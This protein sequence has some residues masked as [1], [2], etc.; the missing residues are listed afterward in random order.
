ML[1]GGGGQSSLPYYSLN[2][3]KEAGGHAVSMLR[4]GGGEQCEGRC[5]CLCRHSRIQRQEDTHSACFLQRHALSM[6]LTESLT[7][8]RTQ[9]LTETRTRVL[10]PLTETRTQHASYRD[11][12]RDTH[13]ACLL[14]RHALSMPLTEAAGHALSMLKAETRVR[15]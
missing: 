15:I 2:A 6:P 10:L 3:L 8:T 14:Q 7:E 12:Y 9:P 5:G 13:S 1:R 11:S 4:G